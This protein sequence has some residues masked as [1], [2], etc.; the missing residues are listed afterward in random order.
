[1]LLNPNAPG[2]GEKCPKNAPL[3][4]E[5]ENGSRLRFVP[6]QKIELRRHSAVAKAKV[7]E[8]HSQ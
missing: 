4:T 8:P 5:C 6:V 1:M 7:Q 2:F 3:V